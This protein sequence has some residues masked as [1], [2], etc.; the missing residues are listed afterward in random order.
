[1]LTCGPTPPRPLERASAPESTRADARHVGVV[2]EEHRQAGTPGKQ[3]TDRDLHERQVHRAD[4]H[5]AIP[6]HRARN[7]KARRND[8]RTRAPRLPDLTLDAIEE[9]L[10]A[11]GGRGALPAVSHL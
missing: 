1:M 4:R 5:A 6:V 8:S 10:G 9:L 7:A 3:L 2:V 11:L